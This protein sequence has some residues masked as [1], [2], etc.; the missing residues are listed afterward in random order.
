VG[1]VTDKAALDQV[2]V[3]TLPVFFHNA[4]YPFINLLKPA[5]HVMH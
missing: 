1:L 3:F 2:R 5:G 4:P